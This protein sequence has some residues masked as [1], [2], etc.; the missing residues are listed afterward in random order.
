MRRESDNLNNSS[1]NSSLSHSSF[2]ASTSSDNNLTHLNYPHPAHAYSASS[3]YAGFQSSMSKK[4]RSSK[5]LSSY[6]NFQLSH[7]FHHRQPIKSNATTDLRLFTESTWWVCRY[8]ASSAASARELN[9]NIDIIVDSQ[10]NIVLI[11]VQLCHDNAVNKQ[12]Q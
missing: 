11:A 8:F 5:K 2:S 1:A 9:S 10:H 4:L 7:S 3:G 6:L 12:Q